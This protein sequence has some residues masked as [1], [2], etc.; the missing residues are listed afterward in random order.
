MHTG[1]TLFAQVMDFLPWTNFRRIVTRY[2]G[3][4]RIRKCGWLEQGFL[5]VR[6]ETCHAE[7]LVAVPSGSAG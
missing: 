3:D 1:K 2:R 5:W 6:C 7:N 4:Y